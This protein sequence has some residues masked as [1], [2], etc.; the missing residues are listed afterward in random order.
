MSD[1]VI[2]LNVLGTFMEDIAMSNVDSTMII[3]I[4]RSVSLL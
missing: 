4:K 3:T 2:N 1:V